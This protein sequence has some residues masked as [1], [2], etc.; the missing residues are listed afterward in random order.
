MMPDNEARVELVASLL[1]Q[2]DL[3]AGSQHTCVCGYLLWQDGGTTMARHRAMVIV[4]AENELMARLE[5][6]RL[7]QQAVMRLAQ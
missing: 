6:E 5:G 4:M 3:A 1:L 2:H 7:R